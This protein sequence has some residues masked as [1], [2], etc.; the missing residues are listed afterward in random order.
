MRDGRL[1]RAAVFRELTG[2]LEQRLAAPAAQPAAMRVSEV[3]TAALASL[4]GEPVTRTLVDALSVSDRQFLM[5]ALALQLDAGRQWRQLSCTRCESLSDI[6]FELSELPVSSAGAGYP[7]TEV[8]TGGRCLRLRVP[9]GEDEIAVA[10][11]QPR[12]ARAL[13]AARCV[14]AIDAQPRPA[15]THPALSAADIDA[16]DAALDALAPQVATALST[17]CSQCGL[18]QQLEIDPYRLWCADAGA[19]YA[20]VHALALRYHWS[21]A[22]CLRLPRERRRLYLQLIDQSLGVHH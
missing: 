1:V 11:L 5:L 19:L 21:E 22:Q 14:V 6:G 4:G 17:A 2:R 9:S 15:A 7:F 20:E 16:I 8:S 12:H 18:P 13:L 3:L 10:G